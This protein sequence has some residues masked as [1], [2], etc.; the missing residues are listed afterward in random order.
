MKSLIERG[1]T[2]FKR[3]WW[4]G[5]VGV[6]VLTSL[7][8]WRGWCFDTGSYAEELAKERAQKLAMFERES[9]SGRM[10]VEVWHAVNAALEEHERRLRRASPP[11]VRRCG[12]YCR[13][14]CGVTWSLTGEGF[15]LIGLDECVVAMDAGATYIVDLRDN[16]RVIGRTGR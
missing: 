7:L 12:P 9:P 5:W 11:D 4:L 14:L 15:A 6:A 10:P 16:F 13:E 1:T 3:S 2:K 8:P